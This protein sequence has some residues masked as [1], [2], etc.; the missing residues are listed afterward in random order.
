MKGAFAG[1]VTMVCSPPFGN[2]SKIPYRSAAFL[3][4]R[5]RLRADVRF[6]EHDTRRAHVGV[7]GVGAETV[8]MDHQ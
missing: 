6:L 3:R 1:A 5:D 2:A 4:I 8:R 7:D